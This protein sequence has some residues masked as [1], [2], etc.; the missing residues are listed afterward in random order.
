MKEID[1]P[2]QCYPYDTAVSS[3]DSVV[4]TELVRLAKD[5]AKNDQEA[6]PPEPT[7]ITTSEPCSGNNEM[8]VSCLMDHEAPKFMMMLYVHSYLYL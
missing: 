1:Y 6:P 4:G 3:T 7:S 5:T 2:A 8:R